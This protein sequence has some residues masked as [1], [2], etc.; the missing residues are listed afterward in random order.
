MIDNK[1]EISNGA[2]IERDWDSAISLLQKYGYELDK[3]N[4][5]FEEFRNKRFQEKY[6][7]KPMEI[8]KNL[9]LQIAQLNDEISILE[10]NMLNVARDFLN[11]NVIWI[12]EGK[13]GHVRKTEDFQEMIEYLTENRHDRYYEC[14]EFS[15]SLYEKDKE[16][17]E[18][19]G[20]YIDSLSV[21]YDSEEVRDGKKESDDSIVEDEFKNPLNSLDY[22]TLDK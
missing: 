8:S 5:E 6:E 20:K 7:G 21:P 19:F 2:P 12:K 14:L 4:K 15:N 3:K 10:D 22:W 13:I 1:E 17:W 9:I 18:E 11:E 16:L